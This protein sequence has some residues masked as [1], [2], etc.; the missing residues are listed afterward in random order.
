[1][2]LNTYMNLIV[3]ILIFHSFLQ[4]QKKPQGGYY[5]NQGYLFKEGKLCIRH[6]SHR[7]LL[8]KEMHEGVL[9]GILG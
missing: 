7:K 6:G 1:L 2:D 8:V 4:C 3:K 5:V 9:W